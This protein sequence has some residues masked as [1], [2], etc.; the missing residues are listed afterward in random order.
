MRRHTTT[1]AAA[2]PA[3]LRLLATMGRGGEDGETEP[4]EST[5]LDKAPEEESEPSESQSVDPACVLWIKQAVHLPQASAVVWQIEHD[6][7]IA[8]FIG[9]PASR[10][11]FVF[12][13]ATGGLQLTTSV[14]ASVGSVEDIMYFVKPAVVL[15]GENIG[16]AVQYGTVQ[17]SAIGSLLTLMTSVYVPRC[18][19]DQSWPDTI[20]VRGWRRNMWLLHACAPGNVLAWIRT[21]ARVRL[22]CARGSTCCAQQQAHTLAA[23]PCAPPAL[24]AGSNPFAHRMAEGVHRP[25][26]PLHGV[27]DRDGMG[28]A[29]HHDTIHSERRPGQQRARCQAEGSR[30]APRVHADSLDPTD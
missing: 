23:P 10:R 6:E 13:D 27:A 5:E 7:A 8:D 1:S 16:A 9:S 30:P 11:L 12:A 2:A 4:I 28:P 18:L 22:P 20:K 19:A 29:W 24:T 26:A 14:P 25:D 21:H 15:T 17:G 3:S